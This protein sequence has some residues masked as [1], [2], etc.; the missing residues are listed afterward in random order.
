MGQ[1]ETSLAVTRRFDQ[2]F[3]CLIFIQLTYTA[4]DTADNTEDFYHFMSIC[5]GAC[6]A[7]RPLPIVWFL[8]TRGK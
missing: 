4:M 7:F 6:L 1:L 5:L 2:R 8:L 3:I